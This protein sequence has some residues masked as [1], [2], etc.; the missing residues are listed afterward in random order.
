MCSIPVLAGLLLLATTSLQDA[1]QEGG[2]ADPPPGFRSLFSGRDLAGWRGRPHLDPRQEAAWSPEERARHQVEWQTDLERHWRVEDGTIVNDGQGVFLT[3]KEDF[4]DVELLLEYRTVPLADSGI[5]LRATPQVQIWDTTE[6]GGKWELGA[7]KGSG[8]LWNNQRWPRDPLVRAD[9][10]FGEWNSLRILQV[11][12]RTSVWLN[13]RLVVDHVPMENYWDRSLPLFPRGPIQLQTHGGEIR[14]R[15][16]FLREIPPVEANAILAAHGDAAF[17]PVF[18]GRDLQGWAGAVD[19][20]TVEDGDLVCRPGHGGTIFTE[21][22]YGD[23]V[24]RFEFLLP[25]G[26]NNG[27]AIRYPGQGDTAYVGMCEVQILDD[28]HPSYAGLQPW[29]CHGSIYGMVPAH[30]GHLRPPG[31]WNFEEITVQGGRIRV[32]LNGTIITEADLDAIEKTADGKDHPGRT[33]R[34]GYFGF[35]GHRDPVRFRHIR[36]RPLD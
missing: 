14:F 33:R 22:E 21:A 5:Y 9:R 15:R 3:T 13:G 25:P 28:D 32:E 1:P 30:R 26:G 18:D 16:L 17:L 20:W 34:R 29:Q 31:T 6:A 36:I 11:G 27:V 24:A 19:G 8:G 23:F 4:G 10:P 12:A 7:D 2:A 35:A